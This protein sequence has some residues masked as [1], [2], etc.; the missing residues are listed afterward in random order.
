MLTLISILLIQFVLFGVSLWCTRESLLMYAYST[1]LDQRHD[2]AR[3]KGIEAKQSAQ[4]P[5]AHTTLQQTPFTPFSIIQG[6]PTPLLE[7]VLPQRRRPPRPLLPLGLAHSALA[8][9]APPRAARHVHA[10]LLLARLGP[11][12]RLAAGALARRANDRCQVGEAHPVIS[13][14]PVTFPMGV[15]APVFVPGGCLGNGC[16]VF[17]G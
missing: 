14:C 7:R 10:A 8:C 3:G 17:P 6:S 5:N 9:H 12:G 11:A 1:K 16:V 2:E 13:V 15:S 4:E